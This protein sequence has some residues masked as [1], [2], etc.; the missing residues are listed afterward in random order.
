ML[1]H[2]QK[3]PIMVSRFVVNVF[4]FIVVCRSSDQ[5][6]PDRV[7]ALEEQLRAAELRE[8]ETGWRAIENMKTWVHYYC[9]F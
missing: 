4:C 3:F 8:R 1:M 7:R 6:S 2:V 5:S 9:P